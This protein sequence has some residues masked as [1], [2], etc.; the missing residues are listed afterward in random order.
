MRLT[1]VL[2]LVLLASASFAADRESCAREESPDRIIECIE[3]GIFNPCDWGGGP[4]SFSSAQCARASLE[5]ANRELRATEHRVED[6]LRQSSSTEAQA[7]FALTQQQ[8]NTFRESYC[9][10]V[11]SLDPH[12]TSSD[13]RTLNTSACEERLAKER[14]KE[15]KVL[16]D[17]DY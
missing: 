6:R 3:T 16:L 9:H 5:I 12:E 2:P 7:R 13:W 11:E 17:A 4:H 10:F 14:N 1:I 8:W 15:L